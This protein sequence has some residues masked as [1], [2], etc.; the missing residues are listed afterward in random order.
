MRCPNDCPA[1]TAVLAAARADLEALTAAIAAP[2]DDLLTSWAVGSDRPVE[3]AVS[4]IRWHFLGRIAI[5]SSA[6]RA[7]PTRSPTALNSERRNDD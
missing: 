2:P 7:T 6:I 1:C 3:D 5:S 4:A